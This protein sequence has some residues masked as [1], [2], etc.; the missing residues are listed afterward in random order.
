MGNSSSQQG[1]DSPRRMK[2]GQAP[3]S[4]KGMELSK[5]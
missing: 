2:N 3:A 5:C 4:T 1:T